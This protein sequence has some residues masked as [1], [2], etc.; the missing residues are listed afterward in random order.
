MRT[1]LLLGKVIVLLYAVVA[2]AEFLL[3]LNESLRI[4][5]EEVS[6]RNY[7]RE[8][9]RHIDLQW[10]QTDPQPDPFSPPLLVF[11]NKDSD[12]EGRLNM[13]FEATRMPPSRTW[14]SYDFLQPKE[15]AGT[16]AYTVTSNS[17]GFRGKEYAQEKPGGTYRI[18][19][20]GSYH[21]FGHGVNN[22]ET[23]PAQLEKTLRAN[24]GKE[25]EVWNGGRHAA[26]AI[27][28]LARLQHEIFDYHPD[29]LILEYGFVDP[30]VF[31][32]NLLPVA[33]RLPDSKLA[34]AA[35]ELLQPVLSLIGGTRV[36]DRA[37]ERFLRKDEPQRL[38]QFKDTMQRMISLAEEK[39]V[40]V[41]LVRSFFTL[42][43]GFYEQLAGDNVF[44]INLPKALEGSFRYP[45]SEDIARDPYWRGTWL[46]G[47]D[48]DLSVL[49]KKYPFYPLQLNR[50]QLNSRGQ[51]AIAEA[52]A[53]FI[54]ES[55]LTRPK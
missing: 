8:S 10:L 26:T 36:W 41:I 32:D 37:T 21:T 9:S 34:V 33:M 40:P 14:T 11:S 43:G 49:Q 48:I 54:T 1:L 12:D 39:G 25:I 55:V 5:R 38:S 42:P 23:Y 6:L 18:I 44:F 50:L 45:S 19:V 29:L 28:G 7:I 13:I 4:D 46:A 53:R 22:D 31:G 17:L 24:T 27:V 30:M 15:K 47:M 35:R 52:L 2:T 3:Y 20:L 16:T 51:Q